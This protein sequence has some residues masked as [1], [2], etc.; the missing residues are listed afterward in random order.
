MGTN[1]IAKGD[2]ERIKVDYSAQGTRVKSMAVQ[3]MSTSILL[4]GEEAHA[5]I[6]T[7]R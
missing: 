3:V 1:N 2:L 6:D 5:G 4:V 7:Y